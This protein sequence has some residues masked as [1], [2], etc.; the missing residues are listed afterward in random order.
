MTLACSWT[1]LVETLPPGWHDARCMW[2]LPDPQ[3]SPILRGGPATSS[4]SSRRGQELKIYAGNLSS[5]VD[6]SGLRQMFSKHGKVA[7]ARV[8]Y[9]KRGRSQ[10]FGFVTMATQEGFDNAMAA[11]SQRRG[12][13]EPRMAE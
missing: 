6:D 3:I 5:K 12:S 1:T 9:D 11:R 7:C 13:E 4:S 2:F 8:A 10:G